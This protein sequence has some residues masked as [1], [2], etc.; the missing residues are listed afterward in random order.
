MTGLVAALLLIEFLDELVFGARE[1]AWPFI[2]RDLGLSYTEIGLLLAIPG[3]F[4]SLVEPALG[5]LSDVWNRRALILGGGALFVAGLLLAAL[6]S[7]FGLLLIAFLVLYPASG[8]FVSLSQAALMDADPARREHNMARWTLAGSVGVVAG[9]LMLSVAVALGISWRGL[10][11]AFAALT[12]V[13]LAGAWRQPLHAPGNHA[14]ADPASPDDEPSLTLRAGLR[15]AWGA[16]RRREVLRWLALLQFGDLM[17]DILLGFLAL[18]FVDVA[19]VSPA[20]AGLAV[21][22]WTGVGLLGD[23]LLIPL[24]ARVPGLRYLR[25]SAALVAALFPLFLLAEPLA[26]KLAALGALGLLNSGWYA[27]PMA[28]LYAALPGQSGAALAASNLAGLAGSLLPLAIGAVAQVAGLEVALW[29][30]LAGPLA[31]LVGL[32]QPGVSAPVE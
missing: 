24:L 9:P 31:L 27:I 7:G 14:A 5:V 11:A 13:A 10:F 25:L 21:A 4:S 2:R 22:V 23:A 28:Q 6:S 20:I 19:G 16:V 17:L 3:L 30:L 29:L 15:A 1:A 8:A 32:P 26:L 18:Y 12:L